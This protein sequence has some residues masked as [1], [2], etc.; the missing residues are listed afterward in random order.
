MHCLVFDVT[1]AEN[2][3]GDRF[4]GRIWVEDQAYTIV[5]FNGAYF[6]GEHPKGFRLHFDSWRVS[7]ARGIWVPAYIYS[8]ETEVHDTFPSHVRFQAQARFWSYDPA[9]GMSN[10]H[11]VQDTQPA[12]GREI[13]ES[14]VDRLEVAGLLA[15]KGGVDKILSTVVNNLE[16]SNSL[17]I[18]PDVECRVLLTS[19]LESFPIGHMVLVSRGLLEF[20]NG[21]S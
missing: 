5:R 15:R 16:V 2:A 21:V 8:A 6:P 1:P 7:A 4:L 11:P 3:E 18:E 17:D 20:V 14:A 9:R 19:T 12:Q 10:D 13:E